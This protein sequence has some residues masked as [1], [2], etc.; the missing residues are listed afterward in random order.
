MSK[1]F[2]SLMLFVGTVLST[3]LVYVSREKEKE[4]GVSYI[5]ILK[6]NTHWTN[7]LIIDRNPL[8]NSVL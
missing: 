7:N 4:Q 8:F 2:I 1:E 5:A 6:K 3:V